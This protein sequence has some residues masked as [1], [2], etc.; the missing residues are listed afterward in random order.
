M[1]LQPTSLKLKILLAFM[2]LFSFHLN[3]QWIQVTPNNYDF[4]TS[5]NVTYTNS[6][7]DPNYTY[8]WYIEDYADFDWTG[9]PIILGPGFGTSFSINTGSFGSGC[10]IRLNQYDMNANL[11]GSSSVPMVSSVGNNLIPVYSNYMGCGDLQVPPH[12]EP[13]STSPLRWA[14]WYKNGVA[15]GVQSYYFSGPLT[16]S[17]VYEFKT[18]LTCGDTMTTGPIPVTRPSKPTISTQGSTTICQGDTLTITANSSITIHN[19]TKDN[20]VIPGSSGL[21][22]IKATQAGS[23]RVQGRYSS[24]GGT[25]CY[26]FSEPIVVSVNPGAFITS[27]IYQVCNGDSVLLTCTPANSYVWKKNGNVISGA[28]GQTLWV[29]TSGQYRVITSGL[30]CNTSSIKRYYL[31]NNP[32]YIRFSQ[33]KCFSMFRCRSHHRIRL[34][35]FLLSMV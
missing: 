7:V 32:T 23:Y 10:R 20:V 1:Q 3:A 27:P 26:I 22:S 8:E 35:Y 9:Q 11:V 14:M 24:G 12:F 34:E 18:K 16:D 19:W 2:L 33:W 31:F 30:V 28:N 15:T 13:W 6:F 5:Q 17:A 29:K 21:T 4:C 25:Y